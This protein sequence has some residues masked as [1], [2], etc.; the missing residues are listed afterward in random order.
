MMEQTELLR[1]KILVVEGNPDELQATHKIIKTL[2]YKATL[3]SDG[4]TA[5][6]IYNKGYHI[7]LIDVELPDISA[8]HVTQRIRETDIGKSICIVAMTSTASEESI[9]MFLDAGIDGLLN[10]PISPHELS[11]VISQYIASV[12]FH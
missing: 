8:I 3:V 10:K 7:I 9:Q 11:K 4:K 12:H 6:D 1:Q 2:G 5:L